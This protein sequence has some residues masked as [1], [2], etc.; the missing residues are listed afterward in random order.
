MRIVHVANAYAPRSGGIRTAMHALAHEYLRSG[1]EP[2]LVVPGPTAHVHH[3]AGVRVVQVPAPRVPGAPGYRMVVR[4]AVVRSVLEALAPDR[5]E[6]SDR[7]SLT[8]LGLWARDAGVPSL[9]M[10]HER[11]DGVLAAFW[12]GA[13]SGARPAG[14]VR[15]L[16]P[17]VADA[18]N[19]RTLGRFDRLVAT[20]EFAAGEVER[21]AARR[22]PAGPGGQ[23][24]A[25]GLPP[26]HR[27][28]LGVDLDRFTPDRFE[29]PLRRCLAPRGETVVLVVSRLSREKRVD[30]AVD[31]VGRLV[32]DGVGV[33]LVV[34]GS[35]PQLTAL[36]RRA[37]RLGID[38]RFC[39][40]VP[41]RDRVAA[42]LASADVVVAP[43]P[44]ETFGLA[45]L[46]ALASGT[47]VVCSATSALPEVVGA[48]GAWASPEPGPLALA[49]REVLDRPVAARRAAARARAE[50]FGWAATGEAMLALHHATSAG[51]SARTGPPPRAD[52][53]P[54]AR[55]GDGGA[56]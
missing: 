48:A 25:H 22:R 52:M 7:A 9:V 46:E 41:Q 31:A 28:P 1:H 45:A 23:D 43:G 4:P 8:G 53:R 47:P 21:L 51:P 29:A 2:V 56:R 49:V 33:R 11:L 55:V 50:L 6:V 20:T 16:T 18:W 40:F 32:A 44:I 19:A 26:L 39:G 35:G 38:H 3:A 37:Q 5:L 10:L 14:A 36:R 54:V 17:V 15:A 42:L 30:L 34:A 27:V 24:G 12:P 13:G